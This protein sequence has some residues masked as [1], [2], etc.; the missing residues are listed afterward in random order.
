MK[1]II[2]SILA[3][4]CLFSQTAYAGSI[5][6]GESMTSNMLFL[7]YNDPGYSAGYSEDTTHSPGKS[8]YVDYASAT[9]NTAVKLNKGVKIDPRYNVYVEGYIKGVEK[10]FTPSNSSIIIAGCDRYDADGNYKGFEN[11]F[12]KSQYEESGWTKVYG[13]F[14]TDTYEADSISFGF[15]WTRTAANADAYGRLY[16]D[17]F[18]AL[19]VP[20]SIK[21][22][23]VDAENAL[24]L[25]N[26]R[27]IGIDNYGSARDI[28]AKD[29]VKYTVVGGNAY[30][31]ENNVLHNDSDSAQTVEIKADFLS[32]EYKFRVNFKTGAE[33]IE[34][35]EPYEKDGSYSVT[36]SNKTT[37]SKNI[38]FAICI[39]EK[40]RM[41]GVVP[42]EYT[43]PIGESVWESS[44]VE[45][46]YYVSSP[47]IKIVK[48]Y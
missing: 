3:A 12:L 1:K 7:H 40:G 4:A 9:G 37:E 32:L 43:A 48:L 24:N 21:V 6:Y 29:M 13:I 30:I 28:A 18:K 16:F 27:V 2:M 44:V 33:T 19:C 31:D 23:D 38:I 22:N 8:Y 36:V 39:F 5:N 15:G 11:S 42:Y 45:V 10:D 20:K 35:S 25:K 34:F 41:R 26:L 14:S 47:D 46:P 17:D